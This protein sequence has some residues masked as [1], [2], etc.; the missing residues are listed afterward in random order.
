MTAIRLFTLGLALAGA[1]CT[2]LGLNLNKIETARPQ[3][4]DDPAEKLAAARVGDKTLPGNLDP[5][6][7]SAVGLVWK[8][9]GTGSAA[10][11]PCTRSTLATG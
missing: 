7:V 1:G 2:G 6:P 9:N 5:L 8:L 3:A 10:R 11:L 4:N